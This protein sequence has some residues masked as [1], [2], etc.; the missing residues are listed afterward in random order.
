MTDRDVT[1]YPKKEDAETWA[2]EAIYYNLDGS[3]ELT[4]FSG[5]ESRHR[6]LEY[7][8]WKYGGSL[9]KGFLKDG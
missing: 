7:A 6:A 5:P 1:V 8:D 3:I 2:V 9:F 4:S